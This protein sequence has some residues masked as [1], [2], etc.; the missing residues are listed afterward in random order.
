MDTHKHTFSFQLSFSPLWRILCACMCVWA[1]SFHCSGP[2]CAVLQSCINNWRKKKFS[3]IFLISHSLFFFF[4]IS[5][6]IVHSFSPPF[7]SFYWAHA[8]NTALVCLP[9]TTHAICV[10]VMKNRVFIQLQNIMLS[11]FIVLKYDTNTIS[12]QFSLLIFPQ[13]VKYTVSAARL[14]FYLPHNV[15]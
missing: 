1:I 6:A 7:P 13:D 5:L 9:H 15:K 3:F 12:L 4:P 14:H 8:R 2:L 10:C 11:F